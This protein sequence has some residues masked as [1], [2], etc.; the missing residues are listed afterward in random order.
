MYSVGMDVLP[1]FVCEYGQYECASG[2]HC[3]ADNFRCDGSTDCPDASDELG[4]RK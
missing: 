2:G 1:A 3:I 4:C